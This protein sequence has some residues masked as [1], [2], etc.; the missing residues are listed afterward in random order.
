MRP[1]V[2]RRRFANLLS[3]QGDHAFVRFTPVENAGVRSA[4]STAATQRVAPPRTL[5]TTLL[6]GAAACEAPQV[7]G[8]LQT[9]TA[10]L[11]HAS[12]TQLQT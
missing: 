10:D 6:S 7:G 12:H 11:T 4:G 3:A 8:F 1:D 5:Y 2:D 9:A